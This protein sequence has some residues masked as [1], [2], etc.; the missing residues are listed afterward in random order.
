MHISLVTAR[1][2]ASGYEDVDAL[3]AAGHT[4]KWLQTTTGFVCTEIEPTPDGKGWRPKPESIIGRFERGRVFLA[5]QEEAL[6]VPVDVRQR[7]AARR[8]AHQDAMI[9]S[10]PLRVAGFAV[11]A[12]SGVV[13]FIYFIANGDT[14]SYSGDDLF[15]W[16]VGL[17]FIGGLVTAFGSHD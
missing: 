1:G 8:A 14:L 16:L 10:V 13:G 6:E 2:H 15:A 9:K 7:E 4:S 3:V 12:I 17:G 5:S 11:A